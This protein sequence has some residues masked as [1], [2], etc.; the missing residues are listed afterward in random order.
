MKRGKR[1]SETLVFSESCCLFADPNPF[2][3]STI[4]RDVK[5]KIKP[6][7]VDTPGPGLLQATRSSGTLDSPSGSGEERVWKRPK[8]ETS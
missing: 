2:P 1:R 7:P 3:T 6:G 8:L 4:L 5:P